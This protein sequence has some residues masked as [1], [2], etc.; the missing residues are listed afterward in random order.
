MTVQLL[1]FANCQANPLASTINTMSEEVSIVRC[2]PVHTISTDKIPFVTDL[3][4]Q[5]DFVVHQPI[6]ENFGPLSID[7]LK[8]LFPDKNYISFPSIYFGGLFPQLGY[9]R[10]PE[11]GTL[12]GPVTEYH[13][14]RILRSFLNGDNIQRCVSNIID[15]DYSYAEYFQ[16]AVG[17]SKRREE[18]VDVPVVDW[19]MQHLPERPCFYTFNHPDNQLLYYV[20]SEV[21]SRLQIP[22]DQDSKVRQTPFLDNVVAAIPRS[23]AELV[24][25][26]WIQ[27][28]YKLS[29]EEL[30]WQDVVESFYDLYSNV[31]DMSDLVNFNRNRIDQIYSS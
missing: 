31:E 9:L 7:R 13:D 20:A 21:L 18:Q 3:I 24:G 22:F 14:Y 2:P 12:R 30:I 25:G 6:G 4:S 15:D 10:R 28:H 26:K 5:V 8:D 27:D 17:E 11:G 23:V 16:S 19:V 29:G 1:V